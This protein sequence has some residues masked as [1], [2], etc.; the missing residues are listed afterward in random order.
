LTEPE[1]V[2]VKLNDCPGVRVPE[3]KRL[4]ESDVI[5]W[6]TVSLLVQVTFVP[7]L[8]FSIP[9][10]KEKLFMLTATLDDA[11]AGA[12]TAGAGGVCEVSAGATTGLLLEVIK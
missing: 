10:V 9:G 11:G 12:V 4:P 7:V 8:M 2:K 1:L 3:F 5:V 6:G